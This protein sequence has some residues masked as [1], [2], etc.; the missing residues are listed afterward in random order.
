M[1][2]A[3]ERSN[4][5]QV[6]KEVNRTFARYGLP[7][8][9]LRR[10]GMQSRGEFEIIGVESVYNEL[11]RSFVYI[12]FKVIKPDGSPGTYAMDFNAAAAI[13]ILLVN[14]Q[15]V[16]VRQHRPTLGKWTMEIPRGWIE[17]K[18]VGDP[19]AEVRSILNREVGAEWVK[20]F[21]SFAPVLLGSPAEDSGRIAGKGCRVYLLETTT[22]V[23]PPQRSGVH[24]PRLV[25]PEQL[26]DLRELDDQHSFTALFLWHRYQR[27]GA[28]RLEAGMK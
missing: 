28:A 24:R 5:W 21:A 22:A 17:D 19:V 12:V 18:A 25:E 23:A 10:L 7:S 6:L 2:G 1:Q 15:M 9:D 8:W 14:G 4:R 13:V 26:D 11:W 20:T 16:L 27:N 3:P